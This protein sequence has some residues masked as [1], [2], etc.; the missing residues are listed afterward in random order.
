MAIVGTTTIRVSAR[1]LTQTQPLPVPLVAEAVA[2]MRA[3]QADACAL[4]RDTLR[5][6]AALSGLFGLTLSQGG[7]MNLLRR[8][9][10]CFHPGRDA[11][12][13][14][15]RKAE[16]VACDETG[17]RIEGSNAYRWLFHSAAAVVHT[18]SPTRGAVVGR[19]MM[20]GHRL[21]VWIS[22]CYTVR[23]RPCRRA[24][25]LPGVSGPRRRL[26]RRG[27]R[28]SRPLAPAT[29]AGTRVRPGRARGRL[30]WLDA[31]GQA[32]EPGSATR[33]H[34]GHIEPL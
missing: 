33:R 26:C 3:G 27:Q 15:M 25:D 9:Q 17:V 14:M 28:R 12:I 2:R 18:A 4:S 11:A 10:G 16:V 22:D 30:G 19:E 31:L 29:L 34:L 32:P 20:D 24:P 13:A 6:Q 8:A 23:T 5:L 7:L 21:A 1:T